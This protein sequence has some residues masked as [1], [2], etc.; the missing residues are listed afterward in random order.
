MP[1]PVIPLAVDPENETLA[2]ALNNFILNFYG[3]ISKTIVNGA[4]VWV[5]PCDLSEGIPGYPRDPSMGTACYF[6]SIFETFGTQITDAEAAALAAEVAATAAVATAEAAQIA[7]DDALA[8]L[9]ALGTLS[10]Q[11][12]NNVNI[13]GGTIANAIVTGLPT[14]TG[15]SDAVTKGYAD[16]LAGGIIPK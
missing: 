4:V 5:L 12:S 11:N 13:T 16:S 6:K 1:T 9:A 3:A 15:S 14:P 7:A 10:A 2:S 8:Q